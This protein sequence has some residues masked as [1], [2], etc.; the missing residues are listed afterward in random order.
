MKVERTTVRRYEVKSFG[1]K[2]FGKFGGFL[3]ARKRMGLKTAKFERCFA[4]RKAFADEDDVYLAS[5][6]P[7]VGNQFLWGSAMRRRSKRREKVARFY[8]KAAEENH[9]GVLAD[10]SM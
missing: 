7:G 8:D 3:E 1:S 9:G 2:P 10:R 6:V 5:V 4:C